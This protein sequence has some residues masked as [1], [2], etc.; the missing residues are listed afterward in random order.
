M[1]D[2]VAPTLFAILGIGAVIL[3]RWW[4]GSLIGRAAQRRLCGYLGW[5]IASLIF[6]PLLVWIVYL[7]FVHWRARAFD[8]NALEAI[9]E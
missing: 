2:S 3:L 5:V 7:I 1:Q 6:G 8:R 4:L 9:Q